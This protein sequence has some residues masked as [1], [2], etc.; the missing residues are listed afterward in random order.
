MYEII[1]AIAAANNWPFTY[2]RKDFQNLFDGTEQLNV[3]HIFL[4]PVETEYKPNDTNIDESKV[5]SGHFMILYSSGIDEQDYDTR[6]Q[7]YIKPIITG[8][9][10][11]LKDSIRCDYDVEFNLWKTTEIIN[12]LDYNFDGLIVTYNITIT[13]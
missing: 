3:S 4:D 5:Y 11:T 6:Y 9:L 1:K 8:D 2:A 12:A 13:E 10:E 7:N